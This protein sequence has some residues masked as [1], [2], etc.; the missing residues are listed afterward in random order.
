MGTQHSKQTKAGHHDQRKFEEKKKVFRLP[1]P[2]YDS[3]GRTSTYGHSEHH[4]RTRVYL[5]TK[6][7]LVSDP[8]FEDI[9]A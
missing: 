1:A 2:G 8:D 4:D 5:A 3:S 6:S 7:I 9:K